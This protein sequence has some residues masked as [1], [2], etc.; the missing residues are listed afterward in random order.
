MAVVY[1]LFCIVFAAIF[2]DWTPMLLWNG[3]GEGAYKEKNKNNGLQFLHLY[4]S[5]TMFCE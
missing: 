1:F 3:G 2:L 5:N 4:Y